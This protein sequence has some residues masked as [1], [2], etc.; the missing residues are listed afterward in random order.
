[1]Q[2]ISGKEEKELHAERNVSQIFVSI[3]LKKSSFHKVKFKKG[4]LENNSPSSWFQK[5]APN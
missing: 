2:I 1:M 5:G 3:E 4:I